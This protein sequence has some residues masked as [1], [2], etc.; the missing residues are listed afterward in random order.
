M[1]KRTV[2]SQLL[3]WIPRHEFQKCVTNFDGDKGVR[4]LP[5]WSQLVALLFGQLTGHSSLRSIVSGLGSVQPTLYHLGVYHEIKRT[6]LSDAND[7]RDCRIFEQAFFKLLPK[8]QSFAPKRALRLKDRVLALDSTTIELCLELCPW[9]Q[10]HHGKGAFKLHTA[11]DCASDLPTVIDFT[12]G[13][14]HDVKA[15]KRLTFL[16]GSI[17]V[18]DRAYMDYAWLWDLT[19]QGIHFVTRMKKSCKFKVR[20]SRPT[21]RTQGIM[22]D[23]LIKLTTR[24]GKLYAGKL[25][26]VSY[27]DPTT[28]QWYVFITNRFD[29]AASTICKLY[30]SRWQVELFFKNMKQHLQVKKLLGTS[31]NAVKVQIWVALI[32]YLLVMMV[33]YRSKLGWFTPSIMAVLTVVLFTNKC[34]EGIWGAVPKEIR[35]KHHPNQMLLF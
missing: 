22:A 32:V 9:A 23:Q 27:R 1:K 30:K 31:V 11:I 28:K 15:A 17:L 6:T 21:H 14:T 26:R 2:F 7:K 24:T 25:R 29:L 33:K 19:H 3:Q 4:T 10:F 12:K 13:S 5:C 35:Y 18:M 16:P 8:V 20:E 34:L